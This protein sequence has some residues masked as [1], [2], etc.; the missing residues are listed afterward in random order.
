MSYYFYILTF[1]T[2]ASSRQSNY[3]D[4][5]AEEEEW[6]AFSTGR[7]S[8][9]HGAGGRISEDP[10][11]DRTGTS[12]TGVKSEEGLLSGLNIMGA[13]PHGGA[14]PR[15]P[16]GQVASS[17]VHGQSTE[18]QGPYGPSELNMAAG[19]AEPPRFRGQPQNDLNGREVDRN[20]KL[21]AENE[22]LRRIMRTQQLEMQEIRHQMTQLMRTQSH[23]PSSPAPS[24]E[25]KVFLNTVTPMEYN[26][27]GGVDDYIDQFEATTNTLGWSDQKKAA[28]LLGRLKGRALTCV[29]S[30]PDKRYATMIRRL[31]DR[32]SPSDEEMYYQR[33]ATYRKK[34]EQSWEDLAQEIEVLS[35]KAYEGME[36]RF[37]ESMVAKALVEAVVDP[38]VRRKL[39]QKHPRT[40]NEAVRH[41]RMVEAD[42]MKEEQWQAYKKED[43]GKIDEKKQDKTRAID[44]EQ[45]VNAAQAQEEPPKGGA[46]RPKQSGDKKKFRKPGRTFSCY[47][48]KMVGHIQKHCPFKLMM[49]AGTTMMMPQGLPQLQLPSIPGVTSPV[50]NQPSP[51]P[52]P[53]QGN[54]QGQ[55]QNSAALVTLPPKPP[56]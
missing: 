16:T 26:G 54:F 50:I 37:R 3:N 12:Q 15:N 5:E 48:C 55:T 56:Q 46:N 51:V 45:M 13:N 47:F 24:A 18:G 41:A 52:V 9:V 8:I 1:T 36:E 19:F 22:E 27:E 4:S 29:S 32:F 10:V 44:E 40:L 42:R 35:L 34:P 7:N 43:K 14:R 28:A 23:F 31:R 20:R 17:T 21:D 53:Q 39:R 38:D 6:E 30:C 11:E 25:D 33:L 2:M 49:G